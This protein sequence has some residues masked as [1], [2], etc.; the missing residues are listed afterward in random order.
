MHKLCS[1]Y[2]RSI[3]GLHSEKS[4]VARSFFYFEG[5]E[6]SVL[7]RE[8]RKEAVPQRAKNI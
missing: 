6:N 5:R 1:V 4:L 7:S 2:T 8:V 3:L